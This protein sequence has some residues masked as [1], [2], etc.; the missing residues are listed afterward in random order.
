MRIFKT[1]DKVKVIS[2][3]VICFNK[4]KCNERC[5]I[6]GHPERTYETIEGSR[7]SMS[8]LKYNNKTSLCW[9]PDYCLEV[10]KYNWIRMK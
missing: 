2:R 8:Y 7:E 10:A 4:K 5:I 3:Y 1:G 9:L 6:R